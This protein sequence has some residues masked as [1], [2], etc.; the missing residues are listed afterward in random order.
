MSLPFSEL[1]GYYKHWGM[2]D[3]TSIIAEDIWYW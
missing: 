2:I 1:E 3:N